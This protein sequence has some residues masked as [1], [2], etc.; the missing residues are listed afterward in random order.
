MSKNFEKSLNLYHFPHAHSVIS[1]ICIYL[2]YVTD[3]IEYNTKQVW[4][5]NRTDYSGIKLTIT[6][7]NGKTISLSYG[8]MER[9]NKSKLKVVKM[10]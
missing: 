3:H 6:S 1:N 5:I 8:G 4:L 7:I 10:K 9:E 2:F